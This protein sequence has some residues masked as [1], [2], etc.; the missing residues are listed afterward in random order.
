MNDVLSNEQ[1]AALV[2]SAKQGDVPIEEPSTPKRRAPRVR[3]I[4]FSR[5]SKFAIDQLRRLER[6]HETC[7][8]TIGTRLSTELLTPIELDVLGIDQLTW[9]SAMNQVPQ[10]SVCG[11]IECK[12]LG[13]QML[14][15][16][17]LGLMQR[18][19]ERMLGSTGSSKSRPRDLT[20][21]ETALV[22]R[23]FTTVLEHLSVTW[24]ELVDVTMELR[25]IE[26]QLANVNLAPPSEP[27]LMLNMEVRLD[28]TSSTIALVIPHR[29]VESVLSRLSASQYGDTVVEP[30]VTEAMR[31]GL[32]EVSVE[33]RAE[34]AATELTLDEVLALKPGNVL[35]FGVPASD[36]VRL[37]AGKVPA[38][39]AQPGRNGNYRAVQVIGKLGEAE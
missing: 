33:I 6:A 35:R 7:A 22:S 21:I 27:T 3:E 39:R 9:S 24:A 37:F 1:V 4:D 15:T 36:G 23:V 30:G 28:K 5:P 14:I 2:E 31:A 20:E 10:P 12:P 29:S 25:G 19:V 16:A 32:A 8:R 17:E 13:T 38:H 34:V 26:S 18:L 11:V